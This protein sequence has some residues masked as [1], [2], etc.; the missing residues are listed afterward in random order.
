MVKNDDSVHSIIL[1]CVCTLWL[2]LTYGCNFQTI[3]QSEIM[4][5]KDLNEKNWLSEPVNRTF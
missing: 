3:I 2:L 1:V 4:I 5:N